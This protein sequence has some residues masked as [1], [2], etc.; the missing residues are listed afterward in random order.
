ME[1]TNLNPLVSVCIPVCNGEN[2]IKDTLGSVLA[3]T[4]KNIEIIVVDDGSTDRTPQVLKNLKNEQIQIFYQKNTGAAAARNLSYSKSSGKYIKFLDGDDIINPGMIANQV[5]L[6]LENEDCVI[7]SQW[8][9]FYDNELNT[10]KPSPE[11]C[12]QTL[13]AYKWICSSWKT[14]HSMMQS[15]IFLIPRKIVE[16]AGYWDEQLSL[17]D[18][19]DFFTRVILKARLVVFDPDSVLYYRSGNSGSLSN[20][21]QEQAIC[22]AYRSMEKATSN[23]LAVYA[24]TEAKL[25]CANIWQHFIYTIYPKYPHLIK[26][27]QKKVEELGGASLPFMSGGLTKLL[28]SFLGWKLTSRLK[29]IINLY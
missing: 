25:A 19:L 4:Y 27:V 18:D 10:F 20:S 28:V 14:G 26:N 12:W 3:Q 1:E 8:G 17:I 15:G 23:L 29:H 5:K 11:E 22:S 7:S 13:P 6:A 9:R 2:Y 21:K 16:D 24:T